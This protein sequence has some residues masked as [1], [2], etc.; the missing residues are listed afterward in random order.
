MRFFVID[1]VGGR[2]AEL[3]QDAP[4]ELHVTASA[5][6][7]KNPLTQSNPAVGGWRG[8]F[9]LDPA[10]TKISDLRCFL[11]LGEEVLSE[12]WSFRWTL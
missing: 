12:V 10:G 7:V 1:F 6:M 5:G 9:V 4:V 3:P 8:S 11:R 2:L